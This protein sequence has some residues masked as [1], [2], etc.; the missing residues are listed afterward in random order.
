MTTSESRKAEGHPG[1]GKVSAQVSGFP[2][3]ADLGQDRR[4]AGFRLG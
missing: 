3:N 2:W 1:R 4:M